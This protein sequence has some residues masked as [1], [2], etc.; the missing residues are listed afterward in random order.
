MTNS[1]DRICKLSRTLRTVSLVIAVIL[2]SVNARYWI[3][4]GY[5]F[6]GKSFEPMLRPFPSDPDFRTVAELTPFLKLCGFAVS[7]IPL[8]F[9]MAVFLFLAQLFGMYEKL[10]FFSESSV[11]TIRNIGVTLLFSQLLHLVYIG[12]L[13]LILT[14]QNPPGHRKLQLT[15]GSDQ[16]MILIIGVI[17]ILVAWIME[18]GRKLQE[19]QAGVI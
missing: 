5:A 17:V 7:A 9:N 4:D 12:L 1:R 6:L 19:E 13:S 10:V 16:I 14:W 11:R 8:A 18:E 3:S 2:P 15:L